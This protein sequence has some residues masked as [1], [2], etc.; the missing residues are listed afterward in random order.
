MAL[1]YCIL[2]ELPPSTGALHFLELN[3]A[4]LIKDADFQGHRGESE[5]GCEISGGAGLPWN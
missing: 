2:L 5:G 3:A 1:L 4:E